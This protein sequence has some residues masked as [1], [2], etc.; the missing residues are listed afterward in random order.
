MLEV[1]RGWGR[2]GV[3]VVEQQQQRECC[4]L[5]PVM[6]VVTSSRPKVWGMFTKEGL[7]ASLAAL[8]RC[9]AAWCL[10]GAGVPRSTVP[11]AQ[12]RVAFGR[13]AAVCCWSCGCCHPSG[14][15]NT[16]SFILTMMQGNEAVSVSCKLMFPFG[17][18]GKVNLQSSTR[19]V[20]VSLLA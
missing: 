16:I 18:K 13:H 5:R 8:K 15:L 10:H 6:C 20:P 7:G 3:R 11:G 12:P 4:L 17:E 14:A 2:A 9:V 19:W 1:L